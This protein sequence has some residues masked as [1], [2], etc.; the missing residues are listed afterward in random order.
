[1]QMIQPCA[2]DESGWERAGAADQ[3]SD[4]IYWFCWVI[5]PYGS[6]FPPT[7]TNVRIIMEVKNTEMMSSSALTVTPDLLD[8]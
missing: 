4:I 5:K 6:Y 1:M 2:A 7:K 8:Q 3:D